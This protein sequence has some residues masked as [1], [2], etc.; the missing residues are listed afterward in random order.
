MPEDLRAKLDM[1]ARALPVPGGGA[2]LA[3]AVEVAT[4]AAAALAANWPAARAAL[5]R[6]T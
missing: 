2:A 1:I 3:R 4:V 5:E 6:E